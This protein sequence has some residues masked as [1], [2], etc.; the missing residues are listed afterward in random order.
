[1]V[2]CRG[3]GK[4]WLEWGLRRMFA[5]A[6]RLPSSAPQASGPAVAGQPASS[7]GRATAER[8]QTMAFIS[9]SDKPDYSFP[10]G[11]FDVRGWDVKTLADDEKVGK[12]DDVLLDE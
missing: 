10:P 8:R 11:T 1:M 4:G 12:V 6:H 5:P 2:E 9:L 7:V 3:R